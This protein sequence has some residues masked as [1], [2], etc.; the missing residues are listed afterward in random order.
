[1]SE[2]DRNHP[3]RGD[4]GLRSR[5]GRWL[6]TAARWV[7]GSAFDPGAALSAG[8]GAEDRVGDMGSGRS[9]AHGPLYFFGDGRTESIRLADW[10]RSDAGDLWASPIV[11]IFL[12]W[13]RTQL[14]QGVPKVKQKRRVRVVRKVRQPDGSLKEE[15]SLRWRWRVLEDHPLLR[16]IFNS[17]ERLSYGQMIDGY[18]IS[19]TVS[20]NAFFYTRPAATGPTTLRYVYHGNV[21]PS[22]AIPGGYE[23]LTSRGTREDLR[24]DEV[25]HVR[26][27]I[28]FATGWGRSAVGD[29]AAEAIGDAKWTEYCLTL[30]ASFGVYAMAFIPESAMQPEQIS[31]M[32]DQLDEKAKAKSRHKWF[33]PPVRGTLQKASATAAEMEVRA[34]VRRGVQRIGAAMQIDPMV[35][36]LDTESK[37]F[38]NQKDARDAAWTDCVVPSAV[39]F[40]DEL[41]RVVVP[42]FDDP[43]RLEFFFDFSEAPAMAERAAAARREAREDFKWGLIDRA[44][45]LR[46]TGRSATDADIGVYARNP[47]SSSSSSSESESGAGSKSG[48]GSGAGSD[49]E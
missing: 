5:L 21:R 46:E 31:A 44:S 29:Q 17:R 36:G 15:S 34:L 39:R 12:N 42:S 48:S 2:E 38:A 22:R 6:T 8:S 27:G 32:R 20:G 30:A 18:A 4:E 23:V 37:T 45:A 16:L 1:M 35:V 3:G 25:L 47:A 10:A 24:P 11:S 7:G 26:S 40:A 9:L 14:Q 43:S 49:G 19:E 28:D 13:K 33:I 41:N